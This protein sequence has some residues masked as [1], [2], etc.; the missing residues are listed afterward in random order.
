MENH[1]SITADSFAVSCIG[2]G[3]LGWVGLRWASSFEFAMGWIG[4]GQSVAGLGWVGSTDN[5]AL[6]VV[7]TSLVNWSLVVYVVLVAKLRGRL[8]VTTEH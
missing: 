8:T 1:N 4:L 6:T 5:S 7:A 3:W 2:S